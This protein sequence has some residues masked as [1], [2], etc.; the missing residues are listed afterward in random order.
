MERLQK[1]VQHLKEK[2]ASEMKRG[3][4]PFSVEDIKDD[5]EKVVILDLIQ[6][7]QFEINNQYNSQNMY[8]VYVTFT[9]KWTYQQ[10]LHV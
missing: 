7:I 9:V 2:L 4:Q 8:S 5:S 10:L 1:E 6:T 3:K